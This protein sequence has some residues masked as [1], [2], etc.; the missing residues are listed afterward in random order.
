MGN[1]IDKDENIEKK[2]KRMMK[3]LPI[4]MTNIHGKIIH[5][6]EKVKK[7]NNTEK[8]NNNNQQ[9]SKKI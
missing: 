2:G 7:D 3:E 6:D 1:K 8:K 4:N 9:T 5:I